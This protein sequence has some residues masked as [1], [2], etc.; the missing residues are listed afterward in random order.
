MVLLKRSKLFVLAHP[1][2]DPK[3]GSKFCFRK[4]ILS[5]S[6]FKEIYFFLSSQNNAREVCF[7]IMKFFHMLLKRFSVNSEACKTIF[8]CSKVVP[9]AGE[10]VPNA[11]K[12]F[13]MLVKRFL[14]LVKW[15]PM[16][17]K[18]LPVL[19]KW[20]LMLANWFPRL[21]IWF[22][23]RVKGFLRLVKL[24]PNAGTLLV[25]NISTM[26]TTMACYSR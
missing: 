13:Q 20:F 9:N 15:F 4:D 3:Q 2:S 16:L 1:H 21:M 6:Q 12:R 19:M 22:P 7:F 17:L 24:V 8:L 14:I 25:G 23:L 11:I 5:F 18:W 26:W 10:M